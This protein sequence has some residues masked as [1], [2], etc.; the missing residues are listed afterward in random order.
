MENT[1]FL[2]D[3]PNPLPLQ[4]LWSKM[5][6]KSKRSKASHLGTFKSYNIKN[7]NGGGGGEGTLKN[8]L[9]KLSI[10]TNSKVYLTYVMQAPVAGCQ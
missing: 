4:A 2:F 3:S 9:I 5:N 7:K 1:I 10:L 8:K 6:K